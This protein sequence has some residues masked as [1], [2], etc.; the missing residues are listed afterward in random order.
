MWES[1]EICQIGY[2]MVRGVHCAYTYKPFQRLGSQSSF[3]HWRVDVNPTLAWS[4]DAGFPM[5]AL[6][7]GPKF[8]TLW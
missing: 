4:K 2:T 7:S 8:I 3:S 1:E 5:G 6:F